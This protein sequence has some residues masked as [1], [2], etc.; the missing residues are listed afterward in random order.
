MTIKEEKD[1]RKPYV[2][3]R[4]AAG[5]EFLCPA[6]ALKSPNDAPK[7]ELKSCIDVESLRKHV[8]I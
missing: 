1:K 5:N 4:D 7:E 6:D 8:E 3:V 2:W